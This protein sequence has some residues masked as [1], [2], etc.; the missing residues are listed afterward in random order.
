MLMVIPC[1]KQGVQGVKEPNPDFEFYQGYGN[2]DKLGAPPLLQPDRF[3][4][5]VMSK[6]NV[7][8]A[9][10]C[11]RAFNFQA[12]AA[13]KGDPPLVF[14]TV[15]E[16]GADAENRTSGSIVCFLPCFRQPLSRSHRSPK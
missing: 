9:S 15:E 10:E 3:V 14:G 1:I 5:V 7:E 4:E 12:D 6:P 2:M 13:R 16:Y 8:Y 11:V